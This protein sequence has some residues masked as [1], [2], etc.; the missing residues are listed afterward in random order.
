[1]VAASESRLLADRFRLLELLGQGGMGDVYR[2]EDTSA[3]QYVALKRMH[4]DRKA[5]KKGRLRFRR[6]YHCL[7][8]MRHPRVVEVFD[9][10]VADGDAFYTMELLDGEDLKTM[11]PL[12]PLQ[13]C[14]MLRDV[15]SALAFLHARGLVHRDLTPRNVR[16]TQSGEVKLIDFGVLA[17]V[18]SQADIAGTPT[19]TAPET[20]EGR[21]V[22]GRTDLYALGALGYVLLT[23]RVPYRASSFEE[24]RAAWRQE[25][26]PPSTYAPAVPEALDELI[27]ELLCLDPLGRPASAAVV[28]ERLTAAGSLPRAPDL[29]VK[30]GYLA[31]AAMVGRVREMAVLREGMK[32]IAK[33]RITTAFIEAPSGTGKSR[34]LRE[35]GLEAQ[36][37]GALVASVSCEQVSRGPYGAIGELLHRLIKAWPGAAEVVPGSDAGTI[38]RVLKRLAPR[39]PSHA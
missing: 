14:R 26:T 8:T 24:L 2:A 5:R 16:C 33:E 39:L 37:D 25:V 36:L 30:Q 3:G 23:A 1:M 17:T 12:R 18:G 4:S 11:A 38:A 13:A 10:G 19:Y 35:F 34:L 28:I 29:E 20:V 32:E 22:D 27:L 21:E 31:S 6:E 9:Y 15:A 7:A